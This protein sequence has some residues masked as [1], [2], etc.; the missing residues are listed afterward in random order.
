MNAAQL[1]E[2]SELSVK[3][4]ACTLGCV[5]ICDIPVKHVLVKTGNGNQNLK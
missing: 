1:S 3:I 2:E 4:Q 5:Y